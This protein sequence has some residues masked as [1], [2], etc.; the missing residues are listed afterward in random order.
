MVVDIDHSALL[1]QPLMAENDVMYMTT[2]AVAE[3]ELDR[4]VLGAIEGPWLS[5]K[6]G[7]G[8]CL[9]GKRVMTM[10]AV[11]PEHTE[12]CIQVHTG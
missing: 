6:Y 8:G 9:H 2:L 11:G 3:T 7:Y 5:S 1:W 12:S 10:D 4:S